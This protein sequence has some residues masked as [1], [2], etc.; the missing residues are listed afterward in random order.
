M[1]FRRVAFILVC[2]TIFNAY[3]YAENDLNFE[4]KKNHSYYVVEGNSEEEVELSFEQNK[5]K[6]L[7]NYGFDAYTMYKYDFDVDNNTC[8]INTFYLNVDY[9]LPKLKTE[10]KNIEHSYSNYI[11]ELYL[12]EAT[13]CAITLNII[14]KIYYKF[15]HGQKD[16]CSENLRD[17]ITLEKEIKESNKKF[18]LYTNHG[19]IKLGLSPFG[20]EDFLKYC[21]IKTEY[22]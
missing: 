9:T 8:E 19:E 20:E 16:K 17:V 22:R 1:H 14:N 6:W 5:P 7:S 21:I 10:N 12:H 4:F 2:N 15:K 11:D 3:S 13:H 18:D